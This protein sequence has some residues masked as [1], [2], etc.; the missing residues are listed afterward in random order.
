MVNMFE[1]VKYLC[2]KNRISVARMCREVG[3]QPSII[4]DLKHG[5]TKNLSLS[6][7]L[8]IAN[9]FQVST[10]VFNEG[11]L[12]ETLPNQ[13][14]AESIAGYHYLKQKNKPSAEA[15]SLSKNK[16]EL[17]ALFDSMTDAQ[18][19]SFLAIARAAAHELS[20]KDMSK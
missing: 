18:Q 3:M 4:T 11:V 16:K 9:Y 14:D 13:A 19:E 15:E 7:M 1:V 6:N 20:S 17:M 2:D 5:R 8:K 10:D 12:E